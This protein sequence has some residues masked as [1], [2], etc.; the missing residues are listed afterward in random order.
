MQKFSDLVFSPFGLMKL[1][2]TKKSSYMYYI[3]LYYILIVAFTIVT[4]TVYKIIIKKTF[5]FEI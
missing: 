5:D 3:I 4:S 1:T 2:G